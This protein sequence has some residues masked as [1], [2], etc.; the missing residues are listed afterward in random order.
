VHARAAQNPGAMPVSLDLTGYRLLV[1]GASSGIGRAAGLLASRAGARVAFAARR[2][3]RLAE[4]VTEAS[5]EAIA[6]VCDVR[7]ERECAGAVAEAAG[8]LGG[9]DAL[10]YTAGM[11]PLGLLATATQAE[12]QTVLETNLVGAALVTAAAIPHLR[13]SGGR[14]VYVSSYSVRQPLPGLGLYRVSKVALDALIEAYRAEYPEIEFT[15]VVLGN[16]N[17]T[18][19]ARHWGRERTEEVTRAWI[20]RGLFPAPT[21]MPVD[22]AAEALVSVLAL[23]GFVDDVAVM[24]RP[25]D[26]EA[27]IV[28]QGG[29]PERGRS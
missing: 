24:P 26:P 19:F 25:R 21:M 2:K 15:R 27:R 16:T 5:G 28:A 14:A 22:T 4:A 12:W 10:L 17:G 7:S 6:V 9:L 23:R 20:E 18:E 8:A 29:E 3:Q 11:S 13:A 1:V